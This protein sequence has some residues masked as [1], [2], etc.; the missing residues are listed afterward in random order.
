MISK[1]SFWANIKEN[2][3]RRIW[4]WILSA[5]T[6]VLAYPTMIAMTLSRAK[7]SQEYLIEVLGETLGRQALRTNMVNLMIEAFGVKNIVLVAA[8]SFFAVVSAIQGFSYLYNKSKIDFYMGVPVKRSR[9]F[10]VIWL[11]GVLVYLIPCLIGMMIGWLIAA[12]NGVMTAKVFMESLLAFGLIGCLYFGVYHL[13]ILAVMLT[14]HVI[15]TC[16]GTAVFFLYELAV[17]E[18]KTLYMELFFRHYGYQEDSLIPMLSP[19]TVYAKYAAQHEKGLGNGAV[20]ALW[21]L[22]F[23]AVIGIIAYVCYL[24]KP[25]ESAGKAMAFK[26]PQ[27]FIKIFIAVPVTLLAGYVVGDVVGYDPLWGEDN[28][29]FVLFSMAVVLIVVCCLI[30][31]LYE[32]D[33]KGILH[34]KLHI[35]ISAVVVAAVFLIFRY[36]VFG[37][38]TYLPET[39]AVS[40]AALVTP[41]SSSYYCGNNYLDENLDYIVKDEYVKENMYLT[42]IGAVNKLVKKSIDAISSYD[43]FNQLYADKAASWYTLSVIYRMDSRRTVSRKIFVNVNDPETMELLDRLQGSDEYINSAYISAAEK[44]E[45]LLAD[46]SIDIA[47][48]YGSNIYE[49]NLTREEASKLLALYKEDIK[50]SSFSQTRESVP[51]GSLRINIVIRKETYTSYRESEIRIYPFYKRC[52]EYLKEQGYYMENFLNPEDIEK[53]QVTNYNFAAAQEGQELSAQLYQ[54]DADARLAVGAVA[55]TGSADASEYV[56]FAVYDKEE[57]IRALSRILY[58]LNWIF[59]GWDMTASY[60][61]DYRV[62]IYF[63]PGKGGNADS[64]GVESF[65]FLKGEVPEFIKENTEYRDADP[66]LY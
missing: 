1:N 13:T 62:T 3:K 20:T 61:N 39:E 34:K 65:V 38:D 54:Y 58:P 56:R 26:L 8:A 24:R 11:N 9:R 66:A 32:F 29:G 36:D 35:L 57:D 10:M 53:I 2:N 22:V 28:P 44:L 15:I 49:Q 46:E 5:L 42:D 43:D 37:Y 63:K 30:Q 33:I 59:D 18:L 14:G 51:T 25:A 19:F 47:A 6:Y 52:V 40:S 23:A 45:S 55:A 48:V 64:A 50:E 60:E 7:T 16:L 4:L 27:P 31:V 41:Y 21:L 12:G 17:R